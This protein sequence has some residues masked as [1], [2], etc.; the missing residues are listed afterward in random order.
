MTT[1]KKLDDVLKY[2]DNENDNFEDFRNIKSKFEDLKNKELDLILDKLFLDGY[3]I[4]K[5]STSENADKLLPPSYYRITFHGKLF[6]SRGGYQIETNANKWK[7][8]WIKTKTVA[9]T[10]NAIIILI[11]A[12]LGIFISYESKQKDTII[13]NQKLKLDKQNLIIDSLKSFTSKRDSI[14]KQ[15]NAP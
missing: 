14:T 11:L 4:K 13:D 10:I 12:A 9:N 5:D 8:I 6:I 7:N 1:E 3:I 2:L 15:I